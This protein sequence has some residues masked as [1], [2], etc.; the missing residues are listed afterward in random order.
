MG[1]NNE[2]F[3]LE[4]LIYFPTSSFNPMFN[5]PYIVNARQDAV[6][7]ISERMYSQRSGVVTPAIMNG[8]AGDIIQTSAIGHNTIINNDWCG[9]KRF[10]F[11]LKVKHVNAMGIEMNFYIQGYTEY[12]GITANGNI[13][14]NMMHVINNVIETSVMTFN[15]PFGMVRKEKLYKIYNVFSGNEQSDLYTQRPMDVLE[16]I[17]LQD[18]TTMLTGY[19][20]NDVTSFSMKN[21]VTPFNN[22]IV[23]S[24]V[25]NDITTEYL[26]KILT[27]GLLTNKNKDIFLGSYEI[28]EQG[29]SET[30]A[31]EPF[32]GDNRFLKYINSTAGFRTIRNV[33]NFG[34]LMAIDNT[35]FDRF[36]L[37]ELN[38]SHVNPLL[39]QTP[40]VGEYWHGQD[41]VTVKAYSL[42]ENSVAL[43]IKY[44]FN[45]L[46]F[47]ASNMSNFTGQP[48]I[49][50]TNFGSFINLDDQ[51]YT[52]LL[53]IFK[54]KFINELFLSESSMGQIPL[55]ME[56]YIDLVGTSKINLSYANFPAT[57]YTIPTFANSS[58]SPVVTLDK[59]AFDLT[60][61]HLGQVIDTLSQNNGN[62]QNNI[63]A[64]Y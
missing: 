60:S 57:W 51:E 28:T 11:I 23:S 14:C 47:T 34:Q 26:S 10:I 41:A 6:D 36:T 32:M 21:Y 20:Q 3:I 4:Q 38:K 61:F 49:V 53:E 35:I 30:V 39:M 56:M 8:I 29:N 64:T 54:D 58:F 62:S 37:I 24:N 43:A 40:E 59:G 44:G 13:D 7:T 63:M 55:H 9:M 25:G 15:T 2:T 19:N 42:I 27:S 18:M 52:Y 17:G 1:P 33:F 46:F 50:I 45:K 5:R 31:Q 12:D 16:N 22:N 48:D